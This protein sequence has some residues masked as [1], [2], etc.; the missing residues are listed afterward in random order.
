VLTGV[1]EQKVNVPQY[2]TVRTLFGATLSGV[3]RRRY[4][5]RQMPIQAILAPLATQNALQVIDAGPFMC[6]AR[7]CPIVEGRHA[8]YVDDNHASR[9]AVLARRAMFVPVLSA[10]ATRDGMADSGGGR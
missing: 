7:E 1:P 10:S 4:E 6:G 2:A 8:L 9:T 3:D 5:Q